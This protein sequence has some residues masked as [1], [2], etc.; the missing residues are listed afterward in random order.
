M[1]GHFF[2]RDA[3]FEPIILRETWFRYFLVPR[4]WYKFI[5]VIRDLPFQ[6]YVIRENGYLTL[7]EFGDWPE[8]LVIGDWV[9]LNL[10]IGD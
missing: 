3:W 9:V 1:I 4:Y 7:Q 2:E 5:N 6:I 10:V 8:L